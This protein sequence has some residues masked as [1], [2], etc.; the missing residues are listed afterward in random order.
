MQIKLR[1][2]NDQPIPLINIRISQGDASSDDAIFDIF[3]D[4]AGNTGWPIPFWPTGL[5]TLYVNYANIIEQYTQTAVAV[6][7]P[8]EDDILIVLERIPDSVPL[9]IPE[10]TIKGRVV[11]DGKVFRLDGAIWPWRGVTDF[12]LFRD[13]LDGK[14]LSPVLNQRR[15]V[16]ANLVRVLGMAYNIPVNAGRTKFVGDPTKVKEFVDYVAGFGLRVEFTALADAQLLMPNQ[17]VQKSFILRV[18]EDLPETAFLEY[19][20]EPFKNGVDPKGIGRIQTS[21]VLTSGIYDWNDPD[22]WFDYVT[23][24]EDRSDEWPRK[25]RTDE[26]ADHAGRTS[27]WDEPMGANEV[28]QPGR[29]SNVPEDFYD[30]GAGI[31]LHGGGMTFHSEAGLN[32]ELWGPVQQ[33]C[34]TQCFAAMASVPLEAPLCHYTRGGLSDCPILH[35]DTLS[36]RTF[37]QLDGNKAVAEVVRPAPTWEAKAVSGWRI[38]SQSGPNGRLIFLER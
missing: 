12:M 19:A 28:N 25:S 32:S 20:N 37:A 31:A 9:P 38:V 23:V 3:T 16:G 14:D 35:S 29:R 34:A 30:L 24:H 21:T 6:R 15:S 36:L 1:D 17:E 18:L 8:T 2:S 22:S 5:Y 27:V 10:P 7:I 11:P 33:E 13:Y 26:W 4:Y